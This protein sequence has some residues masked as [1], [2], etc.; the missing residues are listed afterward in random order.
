[1]SDA[2]KENP[3]FV[4]A[5][6]GSGAAA[7]PSKKNSMMRWYMIIGAVFL[8]GVIVSNYF[9]KPPPAVV[10]KESAPVLLNLTPKNMDQKTWE[11]KSL[12][13]ARQQANQLAELQGRLAAVQGQLDSLKKT[14]QSA[15]T[16]APISLP[17]GVV[18]PPS[19]P[20]STV[21]LTQAAVP[22]PPPPPLPPPPSATY[23]APKSSYVT[24]HVPAPFEAD[25]PT[26]SAEPLVFAPEKHSSTG[27][28][29]SSLPLMQAKYKY[30][31]NTNA[32]MLVAG[33]FAPMVMLQGLDAGT[34]SSSRSNP[35]PVLIRV[36]DNAVLPGAASYSL[37]SCFILG[38]G[39]G[40]MSAERVY[41]R[42]ARL[43]C[44]DKDNRLMLSTPVQGYVVDSDGISGLRGVVTNRQGTL[45][46]KALVAGLAQGLS[47]AL[48]SAQ[49]TTQASSIGTISTISGSDALRASGYSGAGSAAS[50]IAQRYLKEADNIFP[51]I[52]VK[53]GRTGMVVFTED[54]QVTW[55]NVDAQFVRDAEPKSGTSN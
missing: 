3:L 21:A 30:S 43:S 54:T 24:T 29:N 55:G 27:G 49:T 44:V 8:G 32:G 19:A 38:S 23:S 25:Q 15:A 18:P 41:I 31:R 53:G 4:E 35:Q 47:N 22:A 48:S 5:K 34:S 16:S 10:S 14:P 51:V 45:M 7:I 2:G 37:K 39:Y 26:G 20:G 17:P 50:M 28:T 46:A 52:T 40:E 42:L 33:S 1:M 13:D 12:S 6:S 9:Q 36:Q 11:A